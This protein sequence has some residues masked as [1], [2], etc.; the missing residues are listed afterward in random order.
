MPLRY[1]TLEEELALCL[2]HREHL[3]AQLADLDTIIEG[4]R[5]QVEVEA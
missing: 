3:R 1:G 5:E 4:I 2:E